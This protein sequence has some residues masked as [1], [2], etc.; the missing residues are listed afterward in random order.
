MPLKQYGKTGIEVSGC[1][2][3]QLAGIEVKNKEKRGARFSLFFTL[4][5]LTA[6]RCIQ[7]PHIRFTRLRYW[8][9]PSAIYSFRPESSNGLL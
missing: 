5:Q 4:F 7:S 3:R 8:R 2:V 1:G 9:V 6:P